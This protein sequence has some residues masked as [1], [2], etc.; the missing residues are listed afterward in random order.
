MGGVYA[1]VTG[2]GSAT[3]ARM[4]IEDFGGKLLG[5]PIQFMVADHQNKPDIA[6]SIATKWFDAEGVTA[7]MDVAASSPALAAMNVAD[8]RHKIVMLSGPGALAITNKNCTPTTVH[9][10]YNTYGNA[11][12]I[13][14]AILQQGGKTWFF[15]TADYTFGHALENDTSAVVRAAGGQVLGDVKAPLDNPDF[16]S[17]LISAQQS[18]ADVI[19]LAN[20][21]NDT[22]NSVKQASEFGI[23][24]KQKVA[25][26]GAEINDVHAMG[27]DIAQNLL[28]AEAFYW[29]LNDGAR[30]FAKRFYDKLHKMPNQLQA[31]LY[32]AVTHYLHAVQDAGTTD[33]AEVM[34]KMR[35]TPVNDFF[36][37]NGHVRIDGMMVHEMYL[38]Q[39]KTPAESK[40]DWDLYKVIAT[41]PGDEAF[42]P[43]SESQCPLVKH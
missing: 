18:G 24:R 3:A 21:G 34:Q 37:K 5:R 30:A 42:Q 19:G 9:W 29:D 26:L 1:D 20:G 40:G 11:Q 35:D 31:G 33:S 16:S 25:L 27:I 8:Q 7:I 15:I 10:T 4:A 38:F 2:P 22:S 23:T 43:L 14:H 17:M 41:V 12:T 6:A 13:G 39:V 36:T 32:S 28:V